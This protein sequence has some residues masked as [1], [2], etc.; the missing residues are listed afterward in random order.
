MKRNLKINLICVGIIIIFIV[1]FVCESIDIIREEGFF[2]S[3]ILLRDAFFSFDFLEGLIIYPG[4][5]LGTIALESYCFFTK[6]LFGN[7]VQL[8]V[9]PTSAGRQG[10][11]IFFICSVILFYVSIFI[12]VAILLFRKF[13]LRKKIKKI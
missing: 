10:D 4:I 7:D 8:C 12:L 11:D 2:G 13:S 1:P 6:I 9:Q 3:F 5:F